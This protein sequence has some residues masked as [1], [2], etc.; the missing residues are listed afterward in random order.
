MLA[1]NSLT[2]KVFA[3]VVLAVVTHQVQKWVKSNG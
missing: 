3:A 2:K 1:N